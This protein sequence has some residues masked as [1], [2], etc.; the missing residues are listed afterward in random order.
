[1]RRLLCLALMLVVTAGL[2][3]GCATAKKKFIR[4]RKHQVVRPVVYTEQEYVQQYSNKYRYET[5]FTYWKTWHSEFLKYLGENAKRERRSAEE[6]IS[7]LEEMMRYL[8]EPKHSE[9]AGHIEE[10]KQLKIMIE[11]TGNPVGLTHKLERL[12]RVIESKF[13]YKKINQYLILDKIDLSK[14][15]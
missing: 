6:A 12:G 1:M 14:N 13:Y 10:L 3:S 8:K 7:H 15:E 9:L 4:K 2:M 5:H 11:R